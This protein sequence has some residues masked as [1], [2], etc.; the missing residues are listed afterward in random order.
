MFGKKGRQILESYLEELP[1]H[2]R[3]GVERLLAQLDVVADQL[4]MFEERMVEVC[5]LTEEVRLIRTL[6]GSD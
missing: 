6:P 2:S 3:F 1:Q 5:E 4:T